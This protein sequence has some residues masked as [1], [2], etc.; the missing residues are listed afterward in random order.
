MHKLTFLPTRAAEQQMINSAPMR[1]LGSAADMGGAAL[2]LSSP[3]GSWITGQVIVVD[4][5]IMS[6][7]LQLAADVSEAQ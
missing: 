5:G 4:G 6:K 1:R 7:P 3:A 2:F